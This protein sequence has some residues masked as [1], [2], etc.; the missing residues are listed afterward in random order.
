MPAKPKISI[1]PKAKP[2]PK[3]ESK[4]AHKVK[5]SS[6]DDEPK[7][8]AHKVAHKVKKSDDMPPEVKMHEDSM[9]VMSFQKEEPVEKEKVASD[10]D[11]ATAEPSVDSA[12]GA[13]DPSMDAQADQLL[14]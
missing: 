2:Q 5:K 7:K 11:A 12:P 13:N 3:K 14:D 9:Q 8:P 4:V 10:A 6:D 1:K